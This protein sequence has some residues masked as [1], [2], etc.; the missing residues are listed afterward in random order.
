MGKLNQQTAHGKQAGFTLV[1]LAVVM[2]IIGLLIGGVLKGQELIANAQVSA[3]VSQVKGVDAA[4]STFKDTYAAIPGDMVTANIRL[5]NCTAA[6]CS[7]N[8]NGDSRLGIIPN[9]AAPSAA[10]EGLTFW[11]HLNAADL[12][13][14]VKNTAVIQWGEAVP[15][16]PIGGGLVAG[17]IANGAIAGRTATAVARSGHY[18]V[19]R[20][21][22]GT[23]AGA[24]NAVITPS[25]AAR[26]DRKMDDGSPNGGT[27]VAIGSVGGGAVNC[28]SA[29]NQTGVYNEALDGLS[30]SLAVR[31]QQ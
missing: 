16:S 3:T 12:V 23:A 5:P 27:V 9:G 21:D 17:F 19:L 22:P 20:S 14:G 26:I 7:T 28:A 11:A 4:V 1:E 29:A 10:N 8:G 24:A 13:S 2:I 31:I 18:L 30:C 6:P 15:S 25:Q